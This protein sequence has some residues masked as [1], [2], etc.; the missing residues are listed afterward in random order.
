MLKAFMASA[1]ILASSLTLSAPVTAQ[2]QESVQA[3]T[4]QVAQRRGSRAYVCTRDRNGY[5]NFRSG[6]SLRSRVIGRINNRQY[7]TILSSSGNWYQVRYRG[8]IGWVS[9]DYVCRSGTIG[10]EIYRFDGGYYPT[11]KYSNVKVVRHTYGYT[12]NL[13]DSDGVG[14]IYIGSQKLS[15]SFKFSKRY[16]FNGRFIYEF[17]LTGVSASYYLATYDSRYRTLAFGDGDVGLKINN[18]RNGNFG[19]RLVGSP[20]AIP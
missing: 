9:R 8:R 17:E 5:L 18:F 20:T 14:L 19:I 4:Y 10:R 15:G 3:T 1:F 6:P 2:T 13:N 12:S 16:K 11:R 7:L